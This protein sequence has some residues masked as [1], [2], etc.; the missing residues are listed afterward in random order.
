[1]TAT[2]KNTLQITTSVCFSFA[3]SISHPILNTLLIK[4]LLKDIVRDSYF[5]PNKGIIASTT[6]TLNKGRPETVL[7]PWGQ[8]AWPNRDHSS[9]HSAPA[10]PRWCQK[11]YFWEVLWRGGVV[12][13]CFTFFSFFL[14]GGGRWW[15]RFHFGVWFVCRGERVGGCGWLFLVFSSNYVM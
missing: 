4:T 1:M 12:W 15:F 11:M 5:V 9:K 2:G 7:Q 3:F 10:L 14:V 6:Y 8:L 13:F